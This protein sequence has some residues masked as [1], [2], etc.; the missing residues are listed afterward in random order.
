MKISGNPCLLDDAGHVYAVDMCGARLGGEHG[1]DS[2]AAAD[3]EHDLVLEKV[4]VVPHRVAVSQRPD[5][6][7]KAR[8]SHTCGMNPINCILLRNVHRMYI[9]VT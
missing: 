7:S 8:I 4:L 6:Q 9:D 3:V 5:L 2:G 1:E